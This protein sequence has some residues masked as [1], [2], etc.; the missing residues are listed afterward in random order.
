MPSGG[1]EGPSDEVTVYHDETDPTEKHISEENLNDDKEDI[2]GVA[3][4]EA[5]VISL[6]C[7]VHILAI[8]HSAQ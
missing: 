1:D 3:D 5:E 7:L 4:E 8:W 6:L 2:V